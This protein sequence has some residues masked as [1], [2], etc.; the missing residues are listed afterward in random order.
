M[1]IWVTYEQRSRL[2]SL[3]P[4]FCDNLGRYFY[5]NE[6]KIKMASHCLSFEKKKGVRAKNPILCMTRLSYSALDIIILEVFRI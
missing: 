2:F 1:Q 6:N 3:T 4:S 5:E